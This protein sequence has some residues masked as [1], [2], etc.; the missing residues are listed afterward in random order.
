MGGALWC[1]GCVIE[2]RPNQRKRRKKPLT[3]CAVSSFV[4]ES[5]GVYIFPKV[6]IS[7]QEGFFSDSIQGSFYLALFFTFISGQ[8][9]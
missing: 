9:D 5:Q 1:S 8:L 7:V 2:D 4:C 3:R 6:G